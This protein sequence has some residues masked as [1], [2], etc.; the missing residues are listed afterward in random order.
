MKAIIGWTVFVGVLWLTL[1]ASVQI[2]LVEFPDTRSALDPVLDN[3][4][5]IGREL[6]SFIRPILQLA[7]ILVIIIEAAR[8]V[9]F[10]H[11]GGMPI[12]IF[13]SDFRSA[14][15]QGVIA[16]IIVGSVAIAALGYGNVDVL[17][18]L[19]LV[20]VG[21]YFG[22]RRSQLEAEAIAAGVAMGAAT[23]TTQPTSVDAP[24]TRTIADD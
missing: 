13:S 24:E 4:S 14:N 22:T 2:T 8:K 3:I 10:F 6:A 1:Y 11:E 17:K 12:N 21:F 9:G 7:L 5:S 18:D 16:I 20:V 19:A 15:I 23:P